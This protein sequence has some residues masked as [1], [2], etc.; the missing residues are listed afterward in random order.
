MTSAP[1]RRFWVAF[2]PGI[3]FAGAAIG[4]SHLV[5][6]TRAGAVYGLG[7]LG[8]VLLAHLIKYPAFRFGPHYAAA[9]GRSLLHGYRLLGRWVVGL[10][11]LVEATIAPIIIAATAVVTA[12]I[13]AALSGW[14]VDARQL[15]V[16]LIVF[17]VVLRFTGGYTLLDRLTK[18]F[19]V[20]L[21][22]LTLAAAVLTLDQ[23]TWD[24]TPTPISLKDVATFSFLI[25][26]IG[27]MPSAMD[28]SVL[29]SLWTVAKARA[30]GQ[31][32][33]VADAVLDFH[34]GY[35]GTAVLAI[36]FLLMGAG[37]MHSQQIEPAPGAAAFAG[38]V[39][40]LYASTLGGW[41]GL[42]VG[43]AA[44]FVMLTTLLTVV[45]GFPRALAVGVQKVLLPIRE[46]V[47]DPPVSDPDPPPPLG[48]RIIVTA[49]IC[50]AAAAVLLF[51]MS[52]FQRFIDFV[53]IT[54]FVVGPLTAVLNHL[55]MRSA[56]VAPVHR[57]S[58][59][60][61]AWSLASTV[62]L[63]ALALL[64]LYVRFG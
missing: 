63:T 51:L 23:V 44:F 39:I 57:P 26:L 18:I 42:L 21:S 12:A 47:L 10:Y 33:A 52:G 19:V 8:A 56:L 15:G 55:V 4:T 36:C 27:F 31:P 59:L 60:L 49:I 38:Q 32:P 6:S 14:S 29:H 64:Y 58:P 37:V 61:K 20:I 7:L 13:G 35:L 1:Q 43:I 25:A 22:V 2:G 45:D 28:A 3:L 34:V 5:Q 40:N 9:T 24:F 53:T 54:A 16:G 17:A 30:T 50:V 62:I 41:A 46:P 48:L 11:C